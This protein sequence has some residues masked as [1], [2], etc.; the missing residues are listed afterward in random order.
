MTF[1]KVTVKQMAKE[2]EEAVQSVGKKFG[3][4]IQ[5]RSARFTSLESTFKLVASTVSSSG[6][7]NEAMNYKAFAIEYGLDLKWL[8]KKFV[9]GKKEFRIEGLSSRRKQSNVIVSNN[10]KRF[11]A[12]PAQIRI[13]LGHN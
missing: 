12:S 9:H 4:T 5:Y 8:G 2:I 1:D 7:T 10:G 6:E 13:F 11:S 3:V